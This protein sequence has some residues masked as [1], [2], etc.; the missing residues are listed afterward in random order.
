MLVACVLAAASGAPA[1]PPAYAP[2]PYAAE[3][4]YPDI[5]PSYNV[6]VMSSQTTRASDVRWRCQVV[7][8]V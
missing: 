1:A 3:P 7:P 6:S 5:A 8:R 2:A 4:A